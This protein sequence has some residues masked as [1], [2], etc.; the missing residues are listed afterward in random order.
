MFDS[1]FGR[2][3]A[4]A[5]ITGEA[6]GSS[7]SGIIYIYPERDGSLLSVRVNGLPRAEGNCGSRFFALHIHEGSAC[8]GEGF[9]GAGAHF[10]KGDCVHPHHAGDLPPLIGCGARAYLAVLTG[11]F[12]PWEVIGRT[13]IIHEGMDDFTSQPAGNAGAR[14]ACGVIQPS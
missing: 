10:S 8:S 11:S 13:V 7:I 1:F 9:S 4:Y 12:T 3:A 14:I 6:A 2:P 5:K